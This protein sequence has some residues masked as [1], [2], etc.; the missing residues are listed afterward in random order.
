MLRITNIISTFNF[1]KEDIIRYGV[2]ASEAADQDPIDLAFI[3]KLNELK[4]TIK[5][6]TKIDFLP[7]DP[8]TRRTEAIIEK[9]NKRL[10]I[11]KGA[12]REIFN[13]VDDPREV[14]A[15]KANLE[16]IH[17]KDNKLVAVA[18]GNSKEE[19]KLVGIV[20]IS[21][22]IRP[23]SPKLVSELKTLGVSLKMLTGDALE[24]A[25]DVAEKIKLG[26]N[27]NLVSDLKKSI[28]TK[29]LSNLLEDSDGFAEIYPEDKYLIVKRFQEVGHVVGMTGDGVNDAPALKQAEVGIAVSNAND[30]AKNAASAVLTVDGLEGIVELIKEGRKIFQRVLIWIT[31]KII[32]TFYTVLFIILANLLLHIEIISSLHIILF[33]FLT[34]YVTISIATDNVEFPHHPA[35]VKMNREV[36]L[37]CL[38]GTV[39]ILEGFGL[40]FL[41][42]Y[43]F[44]ISENNQKLQTYVFL[45]LIFIGYF[46]LLSIREN[47]H[48]WSSIPSKFLTIAMGINMFIVFIICFIGFTGFSALTLNEISF[49][50][51]YC[52][53]V[54]FLINDFIK[55]NIKK[56]FSIRFNKN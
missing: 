2:L 50:F 32:K 19:M 5:D 24:I 13:I 16:E 10:Y 6:Y 44:N 17:V 33:L 55:F 28:N 8:I 36:I 21:D 52:I 42:N 51:F 27:I 37:G 22:M 26:K 31:N 49:V 30:I 20:E 18:E 23:D 54:V 34:D 40:L 1:Q 11:M 29:E 25:Q 41:G 38:L 14:Q 43:L 12:V 45:F 35:T 46:S 48:F 39:I 15:L 3:S 4:L 7:F 47:K 53:L 56:Y 9:D